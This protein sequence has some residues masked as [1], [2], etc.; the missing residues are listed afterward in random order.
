M[1]H[2]AIT[3]NQFLKNLE[4]A[5]KNLISSQFYEN[6]HEAEKQALSMNV[7]EF[8]RENASNYSLKE[9]RETFVTAEASIGLFLEYQAAK[10]ICES[11]DEKEGKSGSI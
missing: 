2:S 11:N 8:I 3:K 5:L 1:T 7:E 6:E 9:L 10:M 4:M